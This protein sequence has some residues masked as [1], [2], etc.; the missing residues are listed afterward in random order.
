MFELLPLL[1]DLLVLF[2]DW[3]EELEKNPSPAFPAMP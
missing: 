2:E 1:R 3:S